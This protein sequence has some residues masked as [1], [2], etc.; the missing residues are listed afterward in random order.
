MITERQEKIISE[1]KKNPKLTVKQLSKILYVSEP[2][3]R[4]DFTDLHNKGLIIKKYGGAM[5]NINSAD[6]EIPFFVRENE[7]NHAKIDI[8]MKAASLVEDGMVVMLD[9]STSA[10]NIAPYLAGKKDLIC[11]TSGAKTAVT[12]AELNIKTFSTGGQ[13]V[14]HSY[15]YIGEQAENF[16]SEV[17]ADI[18]FFSCRALSNDGEM[19]DRAVGEATLRKKMFKRCKKLV[20]LCDSSKFDKICFYSMGNVA[21]IDMVISDK[22][23]PEEIITKIGKNRGFASFKGNPSNT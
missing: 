2:T 22:E 10:Y 13:M 6:G 12:L 8:A 9:G 3:V 11:I 7:K 20:L 19:T 16:I 15:S 1:L 4:R 21:D 23:L 14:I 18:L 17:N 5:V